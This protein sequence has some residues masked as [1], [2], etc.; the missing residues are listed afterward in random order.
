MT[1]RTVHR[2]A[3]YLV[4]VSVTAGAMAAELREGRPDGAA[5]PQPAERA[6]LDRPASIPGDTRITQWQVI[7]THNS[8]KL[9]IEPALYSLMRMSSKD[10]EGMD[11]AHPSVMDQLN[12]GVRALELDVYNDP[13]GGRYA[14]PLGHKLL[15]QAGSD[16]QDLPVDELRK[17]GF[18]VL[19]DA[20]F[21]FRAHHALLQD[22]LRELRAWSEANP[23]H[24][25]VVVTMNC[26]QDKSDRPG[27]TEPVPFDSGAL[28]ALDEAVRRE[29]G[30]ER[31]L[32]PDAVR[33]EAET[34]ESAIATRGWPTVAQ[35]RGKF[36]FVLD[37]GGD[38]RAGYIRGHASLKGRV[39]FT[40]SDPG[41]PEAA[42]MIVNDPVRDED[43]IRALVAK[44]YY[45]RTR[46]DADTREARKNDRSRFDAAKRS[47][48]QVISTDYELPDRRL[49]SPY[50]V[51][52]DGSLC[53]R[54]NPISSA[55]ASTAPS[56][57]PAGGDGR[58][59]ATGVS[60]AASATSL[61][62]ALD[63]RRNEMAAKIAPDIK[64]AVEQGVREVAAMN[65]PAT[66]IKV[67]DAAPDFT[68]SA[69]DG[70]NVKLSELLNSGPVVL[71]WYRGGWC[72]YCNLQLQA[73]Q[74]RLPELKALGAQLVA[75]SPETP[76]NSL[77]TIQK[78]G[79]E[80]PVLCDQFSR[81]AARYGLAYR[82]PEVLAR[83]YA[84][85]IDLVKYNGDESMMLPL[86]ATFVI[87]RDGRVAYAFVDPDYRRRAEPADLIDALKK[88]TT[89]APPT[90]V[91]TATPPATP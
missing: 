5:V 41:T 7:G 26:K 3:V 45:V 39:F 31:L 28:N 83:K 12:L 15:R 78:C 64:E 37:E 19:H 81:T 9:P 66:A 43:R 71:T 74:Q 55:P 11:Y 10:A 85:R 38:L 79:L 91:T 70:A 17:P 73:Y 30:A 13:R 8:Y 84:G 20:D 49:N 51:R 14:T 62:T 4:T 80:F 87:G 56:A 77:T 86:A 54:A 65:L 75:V 44:G 88:L 47:G 18:K 57:A 89:S 29:I 34:L 72:P 1:R 33:G 58:Q 60:P 27:A 21:D 69:S 46:A 25:P 63:K 23:E 68:L 53:I 48:A 90:P 42:F 6:V 32:T 2:A 35:A 22:Y 16:P 67:G 76:D 36:I 24:F 50:M 59:A 61:Q 82:L 52:F 40:T